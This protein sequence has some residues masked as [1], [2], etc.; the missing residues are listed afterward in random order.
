MKKSYANSYEAFTTNTT[1]IFSRRMIMSTWLKHVTV[2]KDYD[3]V[4]F[5]ATSIS[6]LML[7]KMW[8]LNDYKIKVS[9]TFTQSEKPRWT[10]FNWCLTNST[11]SK[12]LLVGT[13][14]ISVF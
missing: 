5:I 9:K 2:I 7:M 14:H 10:I 11:L 13:W 6:K 1:L 4:I 3:N 8:D 12:H